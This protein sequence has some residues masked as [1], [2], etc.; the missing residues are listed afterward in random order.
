MSQSTSTGPT[1]TIE[2][3]QL[4]QP[5]LVPGSYQEIVPGYQNVGALPI[6]S[7]TLIIGGLTAGGSATTGVLVPNVTRALDARGFAG[8]GSH[9][10]AMVAAY[11]T[12]DQNVPLD[13]ICLADAGGGAA[14][15][16]TLTFAGPATQSGTPALAIAGQRIS[17]GTIAGDTAATAATEF[18]AAINA[19]PQAANVNA[20]AQLPVTATATGAVV[21]VTARN[22]GIVGNDISFVPNPAL[23]DAMPPGLTVAVVQTVQG[24]TNPSIAAALTLVSNTW[25][26]D[27]IIAWQD[28]ANVG[29]LAAEADRR[30][31]AMV[32]KDTRCHVGV[33]G[34]FSQQLSAA[35]AA[36]ARFVYFSPMTAPGSPPW[37]I[38]A[39]AGGIC[40][41]MLT[42]D[43]SRQLDEIAMPGIVGPQTVNIPID[44]EQELLLAGGCSVFR[45]L[46]NGAV[47]MK[48]YV[49]TYTENPEGDLD[50]AWMDVMAQAVSSRIRYDWRNYFRSLYPS[51]KLAPDGSLAAQ[52]DPTVVT[53]NRAK[54]SWGARMIVYAKNGWVVD[55]INQANAASFF[56][57][58]NDPNRLDYRIPYTRI[59]NMIV[60]AGQIVMNVGAE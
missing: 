58:P 43:P 34:S 31:N 26:T 18:A 13:I 41:K 24:A 50:E 56:I 25:Y 32:R 54:A 2:F 45:V 38:A 49:S 55:E 40:A 42:A 15:V 35:S 33:T 37:A 57:D 9:I 39:C 27:I 21:T 51:N 7:R 10:D 29:L 4:P 46:S 23:G 8:P 5:W 53:P 1:E 28:A 14:A 11:L 44:A 36:N 47:T 59:G 16:W 19:G 3:T 6:P 48:R 52:S 60:D 12:P 30:Y 20:T 17:I 22:K